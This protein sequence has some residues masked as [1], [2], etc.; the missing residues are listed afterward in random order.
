ML[1]CTIVIEVST[2][3]MFENLYGWRILTLIRKLHLK[4]IMLYILNM[5]NNYIQYLRNNKQEINNCWEKQKNMCHWRE[6]LIYKPLQYRLS[7][8]QICFLIVSAWDFLECLYHTLLKRNKQKLSTKFLFRW[9]EFYLNNP[10]GS[11]W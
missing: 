9:I 11:D 8:K 1:L 4:I 2:F 6:E 7:L 3:K 5:Q 10:Q